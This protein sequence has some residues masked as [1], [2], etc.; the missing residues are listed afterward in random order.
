M[1]FSLGMNAAELKRSGPAG[2]YR[3]VKT[4]MTRPEK[5]SESLEIR[6][7][8]SAK[9]AFMDACREQGVTASEVVR[10]YVESYPVR[11]RNW[12]LPNV[13]LPEFNPMHASLLSVFTIALLASSVPGATPAIADRDYNSPEEVWADLDADGNGHAT[14]VE[15]FALAGFTPE[16]RMGQDMRDEVIET[17]RDA[18]AEYGPIIIDGLSADEYIDRVLENAEQS[19]SE[20]LVS[21][22]S[23]MDADGDTRVSWSEFELFA[24]EGDRELR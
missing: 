16:G 18:L 23:E 15:F 7:G 5:R 11:K 4:S 22:F 14:Q 8:Y 21:V 24:D 6:L 19:A 20:T 10:A 2:P 3:K 1:Y 17:T 9:Q 13:Q 12:A